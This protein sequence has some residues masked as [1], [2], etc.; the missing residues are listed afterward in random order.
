MSLLRA[1]KKELH[2]TPSVVFALHAS[3]SERGWEKLVG[4]SFHDKHGLYN[5]KS[6]F[7]FRDL[8]FSQN[9]ELR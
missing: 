5:I 2:D 1:R 8:L 6:S 9:R 7:T 3:I 4:K